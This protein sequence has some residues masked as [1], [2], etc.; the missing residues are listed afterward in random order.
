MPFVKISLLKGKSPEYKCA[1]FEGVHSAL[2]EAFRIPDHDRHQQIYEL[3]ENNFEIP[4]AKSNRFVV[5]EIIA[6][7]GRSL[8]A[9]RKL[10]SAITRNLGAAPGIA[11]DDLLVI[12]QESPRENWCVREGKPASEVD[13]GFKVDV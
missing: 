1:I 3:D 8:D 10:Y 5:I 2:V 6:F 12:L 13:L 9:K 11:G 4:P 7:E